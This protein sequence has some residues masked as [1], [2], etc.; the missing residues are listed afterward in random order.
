[1]SKP[2][3]VRLATS[4]D[5]EA[6]EEM[7]RAFNDASATLE[8]MRSRLDERSGPEIVLV[9]EADGLVAG[10]ACFQI[11][12]SVCY[13]KPCAELT[14]LYVRPSR[15]RTGVGSALVQ[16]AEKIALSR[17]VTYMAIR[18]GFK[19]RAGQALYQRLSFT[20][21]EDIFFEKELN[22]ARSS[23]NAK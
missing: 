12:T 23:S 16:Q 7:N 19:N 6:L 11:V 8:E 14:E 17:G 5:A 20:A 4:A 13:P 9:A 15:R 18:T 21:N 3:N 1:M 22:S 10:F 2:I